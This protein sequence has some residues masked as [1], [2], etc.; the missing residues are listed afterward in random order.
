MRVRWNERRCST[1]MGIK[2][3]ILNRT[4]P[5][6]RAMLVNNNKPSC[7]WVSRAGWDNPT[8]Y[9]QSFCSEIATFYYFPF[10]Y[11]FPFLSVE[12]FG[13]LSRPR[14]LPAASRQPN[15]TEDTPEHTHTRM[16]IWWVHVPTSNSWSNILGL[17]HR[18][19]EMS[20][21]INQSTLFMKS[22]THTKKK[23]M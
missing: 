15:L 5:Y 17:T 20:K 19:R 9:P 14:L 6:F 1:P 3:H 13:P 2:P 16:F 12:L 10:W 22:L 18:A 8:G 23:H 11:W 21:T 7:Q 4:R